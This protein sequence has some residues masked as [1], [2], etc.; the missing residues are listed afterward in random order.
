QTLAAPGARGVAAADFDGDGRDD[1]AVA[2]A[3][4]VLVFTSTPD[5][6]GRPFGVSPTAVDTAAGGAGI[7]AADLDA[8]T[9]ID[10]VVARPNAASVVLFGTANGFEAVPLEGLAGARAV[11]I[12]DV[13]GDSLPDVAL[14]SDTMTVVHR[15]LGARLFAAP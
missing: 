2:A 1:L 10:L 8:D 11:A 13:D 14:A 9:G 12:G 3:D 4:A 5:D 6:H 7:A 15:N